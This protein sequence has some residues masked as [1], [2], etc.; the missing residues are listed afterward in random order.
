MNET[1]QRKMQ[2]QEV[3]LRKVGPNADVMRQMMDCTDCDH[4]DKTP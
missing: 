3:F 2:M 1:E 4:G